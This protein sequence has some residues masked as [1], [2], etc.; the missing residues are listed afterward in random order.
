[1]REP[2][3]VFVPVRVPDVVPV[4]VT[5]EVMVP[6]VVPVADMETDDD[7]V[8]VMLLVSE[9]VGVTDDDSVVVDDL[10][11]PYAPRAASSR[12]ATAAMAA[13]GMRGRHLAP[14]WRG[15]TV[16]HRPPKTRSAR[17]VVM[18]RAAAVRWQQSVYVAYDKPP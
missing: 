11:A 8:A 12:T 7:A 9:M 4:F 15:G 14:D 1:M 3:P 5:V 13:T 2:E 18:A 17:N 6:E 10:V 16:A